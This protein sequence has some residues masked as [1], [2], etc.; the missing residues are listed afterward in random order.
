ALH[1]DQVLDPGE[2]KSGGRG[3]KG[4]SH[5]K[6]GGTGIKKGA[7]HER[8]LPWGSAQ[9]FAKNVP[10][11]VGKFTSNIKGLERVGE[12]H[13]APGQILPGLPCRVSRSGAFHAQGQE[14]RH[15][16]D[17]TGDDKGLEIGTGDGARGAGQEGGRRRAHLMAGGYPTDEDGRLLEAEGAIGD[18]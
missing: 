13:S 10:R 17:K 14:G 2:S 7:A 9:S 6:G 8:L 12:S 15:H 4:G 11:W 1:L 5:D 16:P 18:G 3:R